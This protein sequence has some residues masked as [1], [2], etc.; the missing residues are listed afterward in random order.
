MPTPAWVAIPML[1]GQTVFFDVRETKKRA[2][3]ILVK[4]DLYFHW[5]MS[6]IELKPFWRR[7]KTTHVPQV[8]LVF[9]PVSPSR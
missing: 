5:C 1:H 2:V 6:F 7:L 9:P 8:L 4:V 3:K